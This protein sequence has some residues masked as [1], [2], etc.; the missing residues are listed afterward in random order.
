MATCFKNHTI[1]PF[2]GSAASFAGA[3]A[4][5]VVPGGADFARLLAEKAGYPGPSSDA[6]TKVAQF[7]EEIPADR[8]FLLD[9]ISATFDD[10]IPMTYRTALTE[11]LSNLPLLHMPRLIV[12]TNYD[13]LVERTFEGCGVPYLA[14]SHI[15]KG[16]RNAGRLLA[17]TSLADPLDD[18][19]VLPLRKLEERL[20]AL[21]AD[22]RAPVIIYKMHG[23]ARCAGAAGRLDSVVLTENDYIDFLAQDMLQQIPTPILRALRAHRL[24]FLG[25]S[26]QDWNFRVL[27]RRLAL[28]QQ[29]A[30]DGQRRHW[31][32]LR[33]ADEVE[34]KFWERRGVNLYLHPLDR[35]LSDLAAVLP[36]GAA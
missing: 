4:D 33:G 11:F 5:G 20:H 23:T 24:L 13:I 12:T 3:S 34:V 7:L 29:H 36:G 21:E 22:D 25:Y 31:A 27:L 14:I 18:D 9:E 28:L 35:F 32:C 2:L 30:P 17:Y 26:L 6:L 19:D 10:G 1:I 8:A 16:S 15:L